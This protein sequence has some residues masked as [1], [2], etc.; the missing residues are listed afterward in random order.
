MPM[1][2]DYP[3]GKNPTDEGDATKVVE[4][5][6]K[7]YTNSYGYGEG[8]YPVPTGPR[9]PISTSGFD[10]MPDTGYDPTIP[11]RVGGPQGGS[12]S[13]EKGGA[14]HPKGKVTPVPGVDYSKRGNPHKY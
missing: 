8:A 11:V 5:V 10:V 13:Y 14:V 1:M 2:K 9:M 6:A 4:S 3:A 7:M 12:V